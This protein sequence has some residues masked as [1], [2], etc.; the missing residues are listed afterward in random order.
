LFL[1]PRSSFFLRFD[2]IRPPNY[3]PGD[4]RPLVRERPDLRDQPPGIRV[5]TSAEATRWV[6]LGRAC[7][8]LGVDESTLRRWADAGRLRVYRTPGGHRRF[9]LGNLE[10]L[11]ASEAKPE[12]G[13]IGRLAFAKIRSELRRARQQEGGWYASV[14]D[15]DR[16][17]LRDLG[18]RLVTMV[19]AYITRRHSNP[20]LFGEARDV[21]RQYGRILSD[22]GM[23]LP[24]AVEAYIGF[25]KQIDETTRQAASRN[26]LPIEDALDACGQVHALGDQV[27]L[28]IAAAYESSVL[29][30]T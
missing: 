13:D 12:K 25:R 5:R 10:E 18:R 19:S 14:T 23:P 26:A 2:T 7:D 4:I 20:G 27:L 6:T 24:N 22:A 17:K 9:A 1:V 28:G 8:I 30:G 21:G 15:A 3:D 11:V 29:A 16:E